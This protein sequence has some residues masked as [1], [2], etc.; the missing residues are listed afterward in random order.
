[1]HAL[2]I[3]QNQV[4]WGCRASYIRNGEE[5]GASHPQLQLAQ[6]KTSEE[7][8]AAIHAMR[9]LEGSAIYKV[10]RGVH[11]NPLQL[12]RLRYDRRAS[13]AAESVCSISCDRGYYSRGRDFAR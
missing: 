2:L 7:V 12:I 3:G 1:L 5:C 11:R 9:L 4:A 10:A 8:V 6:K 13:I